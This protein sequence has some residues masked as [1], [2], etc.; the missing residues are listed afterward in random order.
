MSLCMKPGC[1]APSREPYLMYCEDHVPKPRKNPG[2]CGGSNPWSE[3]LKCA[4]FCV[5]MHVVYEVVV[6]VILPAFA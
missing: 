6:H 3:R 1:D 5:A 4:G 2:T